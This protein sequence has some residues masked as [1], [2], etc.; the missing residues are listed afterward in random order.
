MED[1]ISIIVPVYNCEKYLPETIKSI[2]TQTYSNF[3]II[4]IDDG[5]TDSSGKICDEFALRDSRICVFHK[6]NGGVSDSRNFGVANSKGKYITFVDSDDVIVKDYCENLIKA[7][8]KENVDIVIGNFMK[9]SGD[10]P[11]LE[12]NDGNNYQILTSREALIEYFYR[13]LPGYLP[14]CLYRKEVFDNIFFPVGQLFEDSA[15][16]PLLIDKTQN[17]LFFDKVIYFYRQREGSIINGK[18]TSKQ[19]QQFFSTYNLIKKFG[20]RSK[21]TQDAI[22]SK[23]FVAGVDV[24]RKMP[25]ELVGKYQ[26]EKIIR[27]FLKKNSKKIAFNP[28]NSS[29]VKLLGIM[30]I[31]NIDLTINISKLRKYI[32]IRRV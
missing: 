9:F 27:E 30:S 19:F 18:F 3:E 15:V 1:L 29:L 20:N 22:Y 32:K 25:N 13:K 5:S 21:E 7:L 17:I 31:F 26:E 2:I 28:K 4:L 24:L 12:Y 23:A 16:M 11:K 8:N 6:E 10:I 14:A